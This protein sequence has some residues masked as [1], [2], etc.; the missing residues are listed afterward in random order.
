M[1]FARKA[2]LAVALLAG[3]GLALARPAAAQVSWLENAAG[4][5]SVSEN[6]VNAGGGFWTY[7]FTINNTGNAL[8]VWWVVLYNNN[9]DLFNV[10]APGDGTHLN[11]ATFDG[12]N[13]GSGI[14]SPGG[15]NEFVYAY[16]AGDSWPGSTPD[17]VQLGQS[18]SGFSFESAIYDA[19][20][21]Q[22]VLDQEGDW[23]GGNLGTNGSGN[24]I[25]TMGG[26]T[27]AGSTTPEPSSYATLVLGAAGL[28]ALIV[29]ARKRRK[30][31]N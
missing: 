9:S 25:F 18:L 15:Q 31:T 30:A 6:I 28:I 5:V 16:T 21:M 3:I 12:A 10:T 22:F 23:G 29:V 11:W 14:A 27:N 26:F 20:P 4:K 8:P 13:P 1:T 7:N 19:S 2:T 24:Q 17:G